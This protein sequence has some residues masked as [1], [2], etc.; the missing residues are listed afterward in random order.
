MRSFAAFR[1]PGARRD[2]IELRLSARHEAS[3]AWAA[4][5]GQVPEYLR[6]RFTRWVMEVAKIPVIVEAH[7]KIFQTS[8]WPARAAVAGRR[9]R[10]CSLIK[11][12]EFHHRCPISTT[13]EIT[14]NIGGKGRPRRLCRP[15]RENPFALNMLVALGKGFG[16]GRFPSY[17]SREWEAFPRGAMRRNFCCSAPKQ[18]NRSAPR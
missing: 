14:P 16:G 17:R 9:E 7:A 5:W 12:A 2:R 13:L 8:S 6:K 18:P 15:S 1:I 4:P 11:Y 10:R 3:A